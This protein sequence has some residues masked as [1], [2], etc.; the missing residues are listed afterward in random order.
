M[1]LLDTVEG[2]LNVIQDM[3]HRMREIMVQASNGTNSQDEIDALQREVNEIINEIGDIAGSVRDNNERTLI[4]DNF[5]AYFNRPLQV[6]AF[7]GEQ[8]ILPFRAGPGAVPEATGVEVDINDDGG[9]AN[10]ELVE[11]LPDTSFS[12]DELHLVGSSVDSVSGNNINI[13]LNDMDIMISNIA[14]MRSSVG[15]W[16]NSLESR[17]AYMNSAIE[18]V[19]ASRSRIVDT[20]VAEESSKL[21]K[22][23]ILQQSASA[24]LSQANSSLT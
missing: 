3:F 7:E 23:Q 22:S 6:G 19:T 20:D 21:I 24:M 12:L 17:I 11:Y 9:A 13:T 8:F 16:R 1:N 15:S 4:T 14:R 18:N 10:S 5:D 2:A